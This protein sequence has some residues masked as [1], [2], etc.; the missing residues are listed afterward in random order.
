MNTSVDD[1]ILECQD[2]LSKIRSKGLSVLIR[3]HLDRLQQ[4][5]RNEVQVPSLPSAPPIVVKPMSTPKMSYVPITDFAW[6]QGEY[7]SPTLS[8]HIDLTGVGAAK[9]RVQCSFGKHSIDLTIHDLDGK[10]Y[11]LVN[12]N[13][14]KDII[15]AEVRCSLMRA[16]PFCFVVLTHPI[17]L[18]PLCL[19]FTQCKTIIKANKI[20]IKLQ[21]VKGQYSYESWTQLTAKKPRDEQTET[22]KKDDPAGGIMDMMK[23]LYESGDDNMKKI[24][25]EA[26]LKSQRGEKSEPPSMGDF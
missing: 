3:D 19:I 20:L 21:K 13:L 23:D 14:E 18:N 24:I 6:D 9:E 5:S 4:A 12:E 11:R 17:P 10:N 8:I 1:E 7:N 15:P 2:L 16:E 26:M 22:K 25:G